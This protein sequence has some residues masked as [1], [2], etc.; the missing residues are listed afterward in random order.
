M[1]RVMI[2]LGVPLM[3]AVLWISAG[4]SSAATSSLRTRVATVSSAAPT[5]LPIWTVP[6]KTSSTPSGSTAPSGTILMIK[7]YVGNLTAAQ[8]FYGA[9]FGAKLAITMGSFAHIVTFPKGGPGLVLLRKGKGD[10][11]KVGGFIIQVPSL[12]TAKTLAVAN[13]A[14]VQGKFA[15]RP[16]NQVAQSIDLLDPWGNNVEIL[17]IGK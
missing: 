8:K 13:G 6:S 5:T 12:T 15:G 9:V 3:A 17:Q 16:G 2:F 14:K 10:A 4:P 11:K 1:R 7:L